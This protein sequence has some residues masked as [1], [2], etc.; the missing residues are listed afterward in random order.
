MKN[1]KVTAHPKAS[2]DVIDL[3]NQL[4]RILPQFQQAIEQNQKNN[5]SQLA[6]I[7]AALANLT[8]TKLAALV[9]TILNG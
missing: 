4:N 3:A 2:P 9:K 8:P 6:T 7:N 1:Q 5:A